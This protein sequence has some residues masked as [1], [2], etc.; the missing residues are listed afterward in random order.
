MGDDR[1]GIVDRWTGHPKDGVY[2]P[3]RGVALADDGP[4]RIDVV[5][6][7]LLAT[8]GPKV[9]HRAIFPEERVIPGLEIVTSTDNLACVVD[10]MG[11]GAWL[12]E[13]PQVRH[14]P[15]HPDDAMIAEGLIPAVAHHRARVVDV[16]GGTVI[17]AG[18]CSEIRHRPVVPQ[19]RTRRHRGA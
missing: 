17:R 11:E 15:V 6:G 8:Q 2:E 4:R 16:E 3:V 18:E 13:V 7:A 1:R 10:P 19:E 14:R 12:S 5:S 9:P